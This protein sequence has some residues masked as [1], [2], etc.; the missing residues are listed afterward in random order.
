M[1]PSSQHT[2]DG[3]FRI[4]SGR[5]FQTI[6]SSPTFLPF[7]PRSHAI[8]KEGTFLD[9]PSPQFTFLPALKHDVLTMNEILAFAFSPPQLPPRPPSRG[10]TISP[11]C[12]CGR[13]FS[14]PFREK[15]ASFFCHVNLLIGTMALS[16][17]RG[18]GKLRVRLGVEPPPPIRLVTPTQGKENK[19]RHNALS[20]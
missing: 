11:E 9:P 4:A 6:A 19:L 13:N 2:Y 8:T 7:P 12:V 5:P 1:P 18:S 17:F 16:L 14:S 20:K 3:L 10:V 15:L